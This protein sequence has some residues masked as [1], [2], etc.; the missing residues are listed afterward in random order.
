MIPIVA[1]HSQSQTK[2]GERDSTCLPAKAG[3]INEKHLKR[4]EKTIHT[5]NRRLTD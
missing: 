4:H 1:N 5:K 2:D 3:L